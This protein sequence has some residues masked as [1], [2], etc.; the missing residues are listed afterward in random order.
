M[1]DRLLPARARAQAHSLLVVCVLAVASIVIAFLGA[2]PAR[3]SPGELWGDARSPGDEAFIA[4]HRGGGATAPENTIPA[5]RSAVAGGYGYVEV[6]VALTSDQHAVLMHDA[7]VDR[8]T[9]G[10]GCVCDL[11]LDQVRALD[12]GSW[13]SS[14]FTG[15]GVPTLEEVLDLLRA[16]NGRA[17]LELKGQW[18]PEAA[19]SLVDAV[20]ATD[21]ERQVVVASFDAMTLAEVA[22]ADERISRLLVLSALPDDI[23]VATNE[24]QVPG[25]IVSSRAVNA[26]PEIVDELHDAGKRV[27]VYT[28]N[29]DSQ[30]EA[31]TA[32]GVDGIVTDDPETLS[33]WQRAYAGRE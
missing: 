26:R 31:M 23:V 5:I 7:T 11:T 28:L 18:T 24:A 27:V 17:I 4:S 32:L 21:L 13:F 8:T 6:D 29:S 14:E 10:T 12:A 2:S 16:Y 33:R 30:W 20:V 22:A 9:D 19:A 1:P 25:I 3:V 15:V